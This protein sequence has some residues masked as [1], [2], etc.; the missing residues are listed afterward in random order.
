MIYSV[1]LGLCLCKDEAEIERRAAAI[2]RSGAELRENGLAG[3]PEE[4]KAKINAYAEI[5]VTRI[6]LQLLDL[7][8]LEHLDLFATEGMCAYGSDS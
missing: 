4:V 7:S 1:V 5:G 8:D 3:T 6:Y 2:G